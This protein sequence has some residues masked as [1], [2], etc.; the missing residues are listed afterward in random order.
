MELVEK[1]FIM[2]YVVCLLGADFCQAENHPRQDHSRHTRQLQDGI[3]IN[4]GF[5]GGLDFGFRFPDTGGRKRE[6]VKELPLRKMAD[7][8]LKF[9]WDAY[10]ALGI[11][12]TQNVFFSPYSIM[13]A[14]GMLALG[15]DDK[16]Q[17]QLKEV[18]RVEPSIRKSNG[19]H[20]GLNLEN[21]RLQKETS[22]VFGI[23]NKFF[24]D[25]NI[26]PNI[27]PDY[28]TQLQQ[29]YNSTMESVEFNGNPTEARLII[30]EWVEN[31]TFGKITNFIPANLDPQTQL[32]L[33]N[34]I[35]FKGK[36][37]IPF[38]P[39]VTQN[40][41]FETAN[42]G[43]ALPVP[44][45]QMTNFF[46]YAFDEFLGVETLIIPYADSKYAMHI[47]LPDRNKDLATLENEINDLH[48][49]KLDRSTRRT[50]VVLKMP[51]FNIK[52]SISLR[53]MLAQ[54][55]A[56]EVF[57][58]INNYFTGIFLNSRPGFFVD[59]VI[60]EA[61]VEVNEEGTVAAAVTSIIAVRVSQ[62]NTVFM[63]LDRPF[64]FYIADE[65][66]GFILFWGRVAN[67]SQ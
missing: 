28:L 67:P 18:L 31:S 59:D 27:N 46:Y 41:L 10:R 13:N 56:S 5:K 26:A 65:T 35:Y 4:N 19:L 44:F 49:T 16:A 47:I 30:N 32:I 34:A 1:A 14:L 7:S 20:E 2:M 15:S 17:D 55:N 38:N 48:L 6:P 54:M 21:N 42:S 37:H 66:T 62:P 11:P 43:L 40:G 64:I 24:V 45:M 8:S 23:G 29:Y 58:P 52:Q 57:N 60:H 39:K 61:L 12:H 22:A 53:N 3:N 9:A 51:R 63:V 50:K 25:T 36:W 33:T